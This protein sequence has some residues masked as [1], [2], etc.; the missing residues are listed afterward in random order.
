VLNVYSGNVITDENGDA[1]VSL[2]HWFEALTKDARYQLTVI[3]T[4][5]QAIIA[6]EI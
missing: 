2:P 1:V 4:F 3:G 6:S 5:A